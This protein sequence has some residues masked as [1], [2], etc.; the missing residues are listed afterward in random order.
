MRKIKQNL[1]VVQ[2]CAVFN[3]TDKRRVNNFKFV[4]KKKNLKETNVQKY[5]R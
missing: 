5:K 2:K 4:I 3:R 1:C